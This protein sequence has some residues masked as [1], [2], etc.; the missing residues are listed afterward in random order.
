MDHFDSERGSATLEPEEP[1][2]EPKE[3]IVEPNNPTLDRLEDQL[4]WYEGKSAWNQKKFKWLKI[5]EIIAAALIPFAAGISATEAGI[6]ETGINISPYITGALG[7]VVVVLEGLQSLYQ[8]QNLWTS[9]RSTAEGLKHEKYLWLAGAGPYQ[10]ADNRNAL[11]ADRVEALLSTEHA[12]WVTDTV[13]AG[14]PKTEK[15]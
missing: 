3:P 8:F 7:V 13:Q 6:T 1:V 14:M 4:A 9:Y 15:S 2:A 10:N 11:F 12:K 5:V